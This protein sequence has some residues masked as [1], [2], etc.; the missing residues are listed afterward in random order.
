MLLYRIQNESGFKEEYGDMKPPAYE[1][2][3]KDAI[4]VSSF[5]KNML[6]AV[7]P[8]YKKV[9]KEQA[10]KRK[11][12]RVKERDDRRKGQEAAV[13]KRI[14]RQ[15][16]CAAAGTT[17]DSDG[18]ASLMTQLMECN[19]E[20]DGRLRTMETLDLESEVNHDR[21][22]DARNAREMVPYD[23]SEAAS[24]EDGSNEYTERGESV[25]NES[26]YACISESVDDYMQE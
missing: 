6:Y 12:R 14:Q 8:L 13:M 26:V 17:G 10:E 25:E 21:V 5:M 24:G 16:R 7:S 3:A 20:H 9:D 18:L 22:D 11:A 2:D 19:G 23:C 15:T 1:K 4:M